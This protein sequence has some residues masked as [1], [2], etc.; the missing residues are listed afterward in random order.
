MPGSLA[1]PPRHGHRDRGRRSRTHRWAHRGARR[2]TMAATPSAQPRLWRKPPSSGLRRRSSTVLTAEWPSTAHTWGRRRGLQTCRPTGEAADVPPQAPRRGAEALVRP[3]QSRSSL[4]GKIDCAM[5][6][7]DGDERWRS[8]WI[9]AV[10]WKR[11]ARR[12]ECP[13]RRQ[14]KPPELTGIERRGHRRFEIAREERGLGLA[15]MT[16][17][18][19]E[20]G[21]A[22]WAGLVWSSPLGLTWPVGPGYQLPVFVLINSKNLEKP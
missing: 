5:L 1:R 6:G 12:S 16:E 4:E 11:S 13:T 10:R 7:G 21:A 17:W 19:R 18:G 22:G 15:W 3:S 2:K 20:W 9:P 8:R 14:R